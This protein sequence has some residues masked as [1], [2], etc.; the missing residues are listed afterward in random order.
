MNEESKDMGSPSRGERRIGEED[1]TKTCRH[2][3]DFRPRL[4]TED[5]WR[6]AR[7]VLRCPRTFEILET[8][9]EDAQVAAKGTFRD[10]DMSRVGS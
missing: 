3:H 1:Q 6:A 4:M 7:H 9:N 5:C 10:F 2:G 8:G